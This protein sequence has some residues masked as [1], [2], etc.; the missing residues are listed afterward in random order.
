MKLKSII[1]TAVVTAAAGFAATG[2][3]AAGQADTTLTLKA[4]GGDFYGK[5]TS[6]DTANCLEDRQVK[7]Y[8]V[9]GGGQLD[10]VAMDTT[11]DKG[12]WNTGNNGAGPGDYV[13]KVKKTTYC[14]GDKSNV[15]TVN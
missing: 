13:A 15:I 11:D 3:S 8:E 10:Y 4:N 2:A 5:V 6:P 14:Q 7:V 1:A 12:K 9:L